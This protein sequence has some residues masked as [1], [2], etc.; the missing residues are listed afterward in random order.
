MAEPP[1]FATGVGSTP[2]SSPAGDSGTRRRDFATRY[3]WYVAATKRRVQQ[4]W[5]QNTID[6]NV[7]A[8]RTAKTTMQFTILRD[9]TIKDIKMVQSSGN[10]SMDN[11]AMR[12]SWEQAHCRHC[13]RLFWVERECAVR[14]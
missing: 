13:R 9:G 7:R 12:A 8:A 2:G 5:L 10:A 11:S 1:N 14:F 3:G 4:N 6:P